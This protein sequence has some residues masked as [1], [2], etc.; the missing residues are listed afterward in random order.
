MKRNISV[1][2]VTVCIVMTSV[3]PVC[4][5]GLKAPTGVKAKGISQSEIRITWNSVGGASG[6]NVYVYDP[7]KKG[8][9][10]IDT[11][12]GRKYVHR[13]LRP[14]TR[15]AYRV[16]AYADGV[17]SARSKK[18]VAETHMTDRK[19][20]IRLARK[21]VG[22]RYRWGGSGPDSFDCSGLVFYCFR[23]AGV[24]KVR[25]RRST[26][27]GEYDQLKRYRV[28]SLKTGDIVFFSSN[29][30]RSGINHVGIYAGSGRLIHA[31]NPGD[32]VC[33]GKLKYMPKVYAIVR[34]L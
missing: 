13:G 11:V 25:I 19:K 4:G 26:A 16:S 22:C 8:Y 32:G 21:K 5:T 12:S 2:L 18:T 7:S 30:K 31:A 33:C 24:G 14:E 6:Y 27:L 29:G 34:I 17:E 20:L 1:A 9:R 10:F 3:M 28:G 23:E 15:K